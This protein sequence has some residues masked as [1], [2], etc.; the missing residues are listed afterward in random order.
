[1]F[2]GGRTR[3]PSISHVFSVTRYLLLFFHLLRPPIKGKGSYLFRPK[4]KVTSFTS[5]APLSSWERG[6]G[7]GASKILV[8]ENAR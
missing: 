5:L 2:F 1:M 7:E 6:W 8:G 4:L 3:A